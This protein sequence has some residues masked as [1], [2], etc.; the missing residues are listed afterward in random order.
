MNNISNEVYELLNCKNIQDCDILFTIE[1]IYNELE[2]K[3]WHVI[4]NVNINTLYNLKDI[5]WYNLEHLPNNGED[6]GISSLKYLGKEFPNLLMFCSENNYLEYEK[7]QKLLN[8]L[9]IIRKCWDNEWKNVTL[10]SKYNIDYDNESLLI[11]HK[12]N[13]SPRKY[14]YCSTYGLINSLGENFKKYDEK[15]ILCNLGEKIGEYQQGTVL[16]NFL[17][18]LIEN[19]NICINQHKGLKLNFNNNKI[20]NYEN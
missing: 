13:E 9:L 5:I 16:Y 8:E 1:N 15:T 6:I 12:S 19:C 20:I 17:I 3:L 2:I 14:G 7:V 10:Y 11:I 4:D 18:S